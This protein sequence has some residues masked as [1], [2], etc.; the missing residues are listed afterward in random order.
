MERDRC[1]T[2][3][4]LFKILTN[5]FRPQLKKKITSLWFHKLTRQNEENAEEWIGRL[6]ISGIESNYK[7]LNR[8]LK[9][10]YIHSLNDTDMLGE[11]IRELTKKKNK[12][13]TS[14]NVL[15]LAKRVKAQRAQSAIMNNLTEAKEFDKLKNNEET[16]YRQP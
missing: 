2:L 7:E 12:E 16:I 1:N 6:Q 9:E 4:G 3:E 11:I 14:E 15:C 8:Q 5:K 13:I 10:Q